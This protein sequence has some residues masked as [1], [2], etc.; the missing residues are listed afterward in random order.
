MDQ[1]SSVGCQFRP[2][3]LERAVEA[4]VNY[5]MNQEPESALVRCEETCPICP[6][7]TK[8]PITWAEKTIYE[9]NEPIRPWSLHYSEQFP[10]SVYS[11]FAS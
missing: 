2:D 9:L 5:Y 11:S 1:L 8:K 4:T 10:E 3:A 7:Q 6:H